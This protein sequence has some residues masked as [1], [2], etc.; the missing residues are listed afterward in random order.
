LNGTVPEWRIDDMC[1]RIMAGFYKVGRD[2]AQVP[3]NFDSWTLNTYAPIHYAVESSIGLVNEHVDVRGE[4][5]AV[6]REVGR[7]STVLLK[8]TNNALPLTG[9]ER[10]VAI[11]GEDA[12][13]NSYGANGCSDRG[14]NN[15]TTIL[16][17]RLLRSSLEAAAHGC[18]AVACGH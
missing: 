5:A 7:A 16:Q 1:V 3:I 8:N 6:I 12:G 9:Q 10:Q 11:I 18:A 13:S 2:T 17:S 14:C 15:G 4:H